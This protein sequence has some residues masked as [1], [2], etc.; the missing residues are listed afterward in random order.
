M[1]FL[2]DLK[3]QAD[4][5]QAQQQTDS[6][7]LERQAQLADAAC[8]SA[9]SYL[10]TLVRQLLVLK[11]VSKVRYELDKKTRFE[12]LP[13][14]NLKVDARRK[15]LR[16]TEVFDHVALHARLTDGR[17]LQLVKDFLPEIEKLESRLRQSGAPVHA[18]PVRNPDNGKLV[19]VRYELHVDF[20]LGLRVTPDHDRGRLA[21]KLMNFDGFETVE[22]ELP[23]IE[24]GSARLDELTRW[25]L[26]EPHRFLEG[27]QALRRVEA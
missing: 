20:V 12:G 19:E 5:L 11:P 2:D 21:F 6:A 18:Q 25:L 24:V 8:R 26:G 23:A 14:T 3:R 13:I 15:K 7:A 22:L 1:G 9:F 4:A 10:D 16:G 17:K 27:A